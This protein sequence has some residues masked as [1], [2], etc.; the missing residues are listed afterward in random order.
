MEILKPTPTRKIITS[1][2]GLFLS[3]RHREWCEENGLR[4]YDIDVFK[5]Y[6]EQWAMKRKIIKALDTAFMVAIFGG[7]SLLTIICL[8]FPS[9]T[10]I[11]LLLMSIIIGIAILVIY[12]VNM[13]VFTLAHCIASDAKEEF[14]KIS[15]FFSFIYVLFVHGT[16]IVFPIYGLYKMVASVLSEGIY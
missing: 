11:T 6:E 2:P 12:W 5:A 1:S 10:V 13:Y 16:L 4:L 14:G 8:F 3:Y 7:I 9:E 15:G